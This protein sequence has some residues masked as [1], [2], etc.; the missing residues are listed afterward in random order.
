MAEEK[1]T[2]KH[3]IEINELNRDDVSALGYV[4]EHVRGSSPS[5]MTRL[6]LDELED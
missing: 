4:L 6:Q 1:I 5:S 3:E 2:P